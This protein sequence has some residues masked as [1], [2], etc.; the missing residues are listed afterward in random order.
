M[1]VSLP[2][3]SRLVGLAVLCLGLLVGCGEESK[4]PPLGQPAVLPDARASTVTLTSRPLRADGDDR[5]EIT[6]TV[7]DPSGAPLAGRSV[8]VAVSGDG[9][10]VAQAQNPTDERGVAVASVSSTREGTKRVTASV[11]A[12]GGAV[13]LASQ[14]TFTF[15]A[16][17]ATRLLFSGTVRDSTAGSVLAGLEVRFVDA[18]GKLVTGAREQ[19]TLAKTAGPADAVLEGTLTATPVGGLAR[20]PEV[21]LKKAGT[22]FQLKASAAGV[23][24]ATTAVFNV[25]PAAPVSLELSELATDAVAGA[26][27]SARVTVRDAYSNLATNYTGTLVVTSTDGSAQ[28]PAARVFTSGDA[29]SFLFT[30]I[31]LKRAGRQD[32]IVT[33]ERNSTLTARRTVGVFAGE[34]TGMAFTQAP[35]NA[36]VRAVLPPAT[37][38]I[39]DGF[40]NTAAVGSPRVTVALAESGTLSGRLEVTPVDGVVHF[41]DLRVESEGVFHLR[42][43]AS[44][45]ADATTVGTLTIV[46]DVSPAKPLLSQ[47]ALGPD[48]ATVSWVAVG[49]DGVEG[50]ATSQELRY[51]TAPIRSLAEFNAATPVG[52]VGAP[53]APGTPASAQ[54]T[55]LT[56]NTTYYVALRVVDNKG[57]AA[58]SD[59]LMLQTVDN[60]VARLVFTVQPAN[61]TAGVAM[62][63][64]EVSLLNAQDQVVTSSTAPV[65]LSL[66]GGHGFVPRQ[67]SAV[68]GVATFTGLQV[69]TAADLHYFEASA[70]GRTQQSN[71]FRIDAAAASRF[72]IT[73][74]P[75]QVTAGHPQ[76]INVTAQDPFGN[77]AKSYLGTVR[78]TTTSTVNTLPA[79]YTFTAP[80]AGSHGFGGV[81]LSTAGTRR[82]TVTDTGNSQLTG[83][84]EVVVTNDVAARLELSGLPQDVASKSTHTLTLRVLDAFDNLVPGYTGS[85]GFT[86]DDSLATYPE[87]PKV[88]TA[89]DAGQHTFQVTF[90]SSGTRFLTASDVAGNLVGTV[91]TRVAP[92]PPA[93]LVVVLSTT[94]PVA[95]DAVDATVAVVDEFGYH[96]SSYQGR[97]ALTLLPADPQTTGLGEYTFTPADMGRHVF[98][99]TFAQAQSAVLSVTDTQQGSLTDS[100]SVSVQAGVATQLSVSPMTATVTAGVPQAFVVSAKDRFGNLARDYSGTVTPTTTD[101]AVG[102]QS[103]YTYVAED[104]GEHSF[105]YTLETAGAQSAIFTDVG[106]NVSATSALTVVAGPAATLRFLSGAVSASVRQTLPT[107]RVA[108]EDRFG[109]G[110]AGAASSVTLSFSTGGALAGD[111]TIAPV[112]G[113]AEFTTVSAEQ[114]GSGLLTASVANVSVPTASIAM[115]VTDNVAPSPVAALEATPLAGGHVRL[116]WLAS[117]DDAGLGLATSYELKYSSAAIN[118]GNFVSAFPVAT[119]A[120]KAPGMQEEV[121]VGPL[122]SGATYYFAV[123]VLDG[124]GNTSTLTT[125]SAQV[126]SFANNDLCAARAP[127]CSESGVSQVVYVVGEDDPACPYVALENLCKGLNGVCFQ[128][129][130]DT[131]AAPAEGDLVITEL[132]SAPSEGTTEY[133][134]LTN[135][136][137][138]LLNINGLSLMY[139]VGAAKGSVSV[140][141]GEDAA[142]VVPPGGTFVLASNADRDT[143]GG[144]VA[145]IAYGSTLDLE[146]SGR[147]TVR[148]NGVLMD[149]LT[150]DERFAQV[151]GHSMSRSPASDDSR[152]GREGGA[153]WCASRQVLPGG[154]RG[155][156]GHANETCDEA[157]VTSGAK[158]SQ[159]D[160]QHP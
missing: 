11:S 148:V 66:V 151:P 116:R 138:R 79:D 108:V 94:N 86:T 42:A 56:P 97:V 17:V 46:D 23:E 37:V 100:E 101:G 65:T 139:A 30:G 150:Y 112:A 114:E 33:D 89:A 128:G 110:V 103:P 6:V 141:K 120:P 48:T 3:S 87:Q 107:V 80:A 36:S 154:D 98:S 54:L 131:A 123:R 117:G 115:A 78:F 125:A 130:C 88:F 137:D 99:I 31:T 58:L 9:N 160:T 156:P 104:Q 70:S 63:T 55:G 76:H 85:V 51:S 20:F 147:V 69:D 152:R 13:V 50:T 83:F 146:A 40:G 132:M 68:A 102:A 149:E 29:G 7:K 12:E 47:G 1:S 10:T 44:G 2:P 72:V 159:G 143:N 43:S 91:S 24:D 140:D 25:V 60:N 129:A 75:G 32:V 119:D 34:A 153:S 121:L 133:I 92:G 158:P 19:V 142:V 21:V 82:L 126:T 8:T 74:L 77:V 38:A 111:I 16:P 59:G 4:P 84:V 95:G 105:S 45:L 18:S 52:G 26:Q 49:D 106:L 73:G 90:R 71:A 145:D 35:S 122:T 127:T 93:T 118:A 155:T 27:R 57:N 96:A 62:A 144:V 81:K 124:A 64:V 14:P 157:P 134:E 53:A 61:G 41:T 39:Q 136:S 67:V 28:M 15:V 113:V 22:G 5:G 135:V 109:N